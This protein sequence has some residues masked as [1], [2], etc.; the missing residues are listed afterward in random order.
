MSDAI[1]CKMCRWW[2]EL[3]DGDGKGACE[4]NPPVFIGG[5]PWESDNWHQPLTMDYEGCS[6]GEPKTE[7]E[8]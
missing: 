8:P 4:F 1:R 2:L 6:R 3:D 7:D 5:D